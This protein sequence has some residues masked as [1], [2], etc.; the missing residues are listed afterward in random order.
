MEEW[1]S[2]IRQT[3]QNVD[4]KLFFQLLNPPNSIEKGNDLSG[5]SDC[6]GLVLMMTI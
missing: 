6:E 2:G 4:Y 1:R 3:Q 5:L